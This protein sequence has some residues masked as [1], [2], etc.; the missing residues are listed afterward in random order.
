MTTEIASQ[1]AQGRNVRRTTVLLP[2]PRG[3]V[4]P[5]TARRMRRAVLG[6]AVAWLL[7]LLPALLGAGP[8]L[9]ALG[10]GVIVPGGGLLATGHPLWELAA[11]VIFVLS[12]AVWWFAAPVVLPPLVWLA[13]AVASA[14]TATAQPVPVWRVAAIAALAPVLLIGDQEYAAAAQATLDEREPVASANGALRYVEASA[15][16]NLYGVLGRFGRPSGLRDLLDHGARTHG[17]PAPASPAP[18]TRTCSSPARSPTAALSTSPWCRAAGQ[19]A[20]RSRW[21]GSPRTARTPPAAPGPTPS[22]PTPT[23]MR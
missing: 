13:A 20:P 18:P 17:S 5:V 12:L 3:V 16:T 9:V 7:G 23:G 11:A 19:C 14:C 10:L 6:Y 4:P 8:S 1:S 22:P 15:L 21:T 2:E